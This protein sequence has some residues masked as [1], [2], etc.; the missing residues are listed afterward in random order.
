M[1]PMDRI[2]DRYRNDPAFHAMVDTMRAVIENMQLTPSE[3]REAAM[4]ACY[5]TEMRRPTP[6]RIEDPYEDRGHGNG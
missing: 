3:V 6:I 1:S 2:D 4:Y 5:Q